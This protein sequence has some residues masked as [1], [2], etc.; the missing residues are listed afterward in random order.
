M[1]KIVDRTSNTTFFDSVHPDR[2]AFKSSISNADTFTIPFG[3]G[4]LVLGLNAEDDTN[5]TAGAT[6]SGSVVTINLRDDADSAIT[7]DTDIIGEVILV[8][9]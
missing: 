4:S 2:I 7:A 9:Q 6:V 1:I 8:S 5:A 3:Q